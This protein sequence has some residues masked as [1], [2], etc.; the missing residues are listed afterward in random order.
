M[1][2]SN[3]IKT[4]NNLTKENEDL[5]KAIRKNENVFYEK[6][7]TIQ[8]TKWSFIKIMPLILFMY[9]YATELGDIGIFNRTLFKAVPD[10]DAI[11]H[12]P[13]FILGAFFVCW[14][15]YVAVTDSLIDSI[16][17]KYKVKTKDALDMDDRFSIG[18]FCALI[19]F[20]VYILISVLL[21]FNELSVFFFFNVMYIFTLISASYSYIHYLFVFKGFKSKKQQA[22][23]DAAISN[24]L[25]LQKKKE[26][27][28]EKQL[29]LR[30]KA[31]DSP[32]LMQYVLD[33]YSKIDMPKFEKETLLVFINALK[34]ENKKKLEKLKEIDELKSVYKA[35][36][37]QEP[38]M[39]NKIEINNI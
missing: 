23:M 8:K 15:I 38:N 14:F 7:K 29:E 26:I 30:R 22:E 18:F 34:A 6:M 4:Y 37:N 27:N 11:D 36:Y 24:T 12:F 35:V 19:T 16:R 1:N 33:Q 31:V 21:K 17:S 2:P 3:H 32:E 28:E 5:E 9:L 39:K 10:L 13:A 20:I 25:E